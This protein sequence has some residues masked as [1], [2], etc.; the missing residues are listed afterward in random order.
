M[1]RFGIVGPSYRSQSVNAAAQMS[2]NLYVERIEV[3]DEPAPAVLYPTPGIEQL[4]EKGIKTRG[5]WT[6]NTRSFFVADDTLYELF[7][8]GATNVLGTVANDGLMTSMIASDDQLLLA[9]ALSLYVFDLNTNTFT[10]VSAATITGVS[11]VDFCDGYFI[12]LIAGTNTFRISALFNALLWDPLDF[13]QIS[14]FP[15][16]LFSMIVDHREIWLFGESFSTVYYDTGNTDFPFDVN[17]SASVI[18][19]GIAAK[20]SVAKID[21]TIIWLGKDTRGQG[22]IWKASGYTPTRVSTHAVEFAI[23]G[24]TDITDAVAYGYQDQGHSFYVIYFPTGDATWVYDVGMDMWHERGFWNDAID[25]YEAHHSWSHTFAFG[26]HLVG[27]WSSGKIYEMNIMLLDDDGDEIRRVR[28]AT[29]V[30]NDQKRVFFSMMQ[31]YLESGLGPMPPIQGL[32][33][34]PLYFYL[35][36]SSGVVWRFGIDDTGL[37]SNPGTPVIG[38]SGQTIILND[39]VGGAAS[40]QLTVDLLGSLGSISVAYL[41]TYPKTIRFST[42]S[43]LFEVNLFVDFTGLAQTNGPFRVARAP[44]I[45]LRWSNDGGHTWS[46]EYVANCGQAGNF[47]DRVRWNRL[48]Q[49]RNRVFEINMSDPIPWRIIDCV[50]ELEPGTN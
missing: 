23:Q 8:S 22:V 5:Q 10:A 16:K 9:S 32:S 4:T 45:N 46:N 12:A 14:V 7:T 37:I 17:P 36:D 6:I 30:A 33:T 13:A 26:K 18:E 19:M 42:T 11:K 28:R 47:S 41:G 29:H 21:N 49:G 40:W 43:H 48:G 3:G 50:L 44:Q 39:L 15:G 27:D 25:E 34:E 24:Y 1:P 38:H 20:S 35:E 2:M 31:V